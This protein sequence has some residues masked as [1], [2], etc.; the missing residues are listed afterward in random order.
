MPTASVGDERNRYPDEWNR[1]PDSAAVTDG[2]LVAAAIDGALV[3]KDSKFDSKAKNPA[4]WTRP[5]LH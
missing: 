2:A 3:A 1:Y 5:V 4:P